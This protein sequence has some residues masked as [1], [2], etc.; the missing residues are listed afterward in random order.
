M[1]HYTQNCPELFAASPAGPTGSFVQTLRQW[2]RQ[3]RLIARIQRERA[4][5]RDMPDSMLRD[6]GIDR[7]TALHEAGR[8]DIPAGRKC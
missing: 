8:H 2:L 4:Y 3:Q 7:A 1:T 5:L 6:I